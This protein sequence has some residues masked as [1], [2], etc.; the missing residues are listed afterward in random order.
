MTQ[1][2]YID[3][4]PVELAKETYYDR[5]NWRIA[6]TLVPVS[7]AAGRVTSEAIFAKCSSPAHPCAAMDGIAVK[8]SKTKEAN[9]RSPL[10]LKLH[11]DFDW[12]N[13][14]NLVPAGYNSVIMIEDVIPKDPDHIQLIAPAIPWQHIRQVGEDLVEGE[15][16]IPSGH[17]IAPQDLGALL[18]GGIWEI[19]VLDQPRIGILPTGNEIVQTLSQMEKGKIMDSTS[20]VL[21]ALATELGGTPQIYEAAPDDY[22][23]LKNA[24]QTAL[25]ENDILVTIAGSSTGSKDFTA[26]VIASEGDVIIHGVAMKPGKPTI[27][28][29]INGK[30]IIGLPGYPAS[31]YL[32]FRTFVEPLLRNFQPPVRKVIKAALTQRIV[33]S[34]KHEEHIRVT[35]GYMNEQY[36][37]T[38]LSRQASST[39]SLVKADG[40]LKIP[41]NSEGMES[42]SLAEIEL[43]HEPEE[44]QE[45]LVLIGSHDLILDLIADQMPLTSAHAG[46]L[47]GVLAIKRKECHAASVHLLDEETGVY[48]QY[49]KEQYFEKD[50]V[51]L[52]EGVKRLQGIM[53]KPGNPKQ[54]KSVADLNR[55]DIAIINRQRGAGTRQLLDYELKKCGLSPNQI[56]GYEREVNTHLAVAVTVKNDDADAGLGIYAAAAQM[57]LEF[58]P[59]GYE[60]YDFLLRKEAYEDP[61]LQ[62]LIRI[63]QSEKFKMQLEAIGGY[64][65]ESPGHILFGGEGL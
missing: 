13:T 12:I 56:N 5:L 30:P 37:A 34:L 27:L 41:R 14:G 43:Y 57:G 23:A 17:R 58:I 65:L 1:K 10:T 61:R 7:Q 11:E 38:P 4:T 31:S 62:H 8:A 2:V 45:K 48:N 32:A 44:I 24:I 6:V 25:S 29:I 59:I 16:I 35:L 55:G 53:V 9:E 3:N 40:L 33:S 60:S 49:L 50:G 42:G 36:I 54:I 64:K 26:Q 47:G 63:L 46:S 51:L 21:A 18:S 19:P 28:G 52:L 20:P 22:E 15:M 39:M